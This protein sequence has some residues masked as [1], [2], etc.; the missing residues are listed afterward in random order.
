MDPSISSTTDSTADS[1]DVSLAVSSHHP[2]YSN[3]RPKPTVE[4]RDDLT[5]FAWDVIRAKLTPLCPNEVPR[6]PTFPDGY[7]GLHC[8]L[9]VTWAINSD[10]RGCIGCLQPLA[11][12]PG[13]RDYALRSAFHDSRF[14]PLSW[15]EFCADSLS[16]Q[17][18]VL[19]SFETVGRGL[20]DWTLGTHG[21]TLSF[22]D[23]STGQT[24]SATFL[25]EVPSEAE[26]S[27][28][29]TIRELA[30]KAGFRSTLFIINE[31]WGL[32]TGSDKW[33]ILDA[34]CLTNCTKS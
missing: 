4:F 27:K 1:S 29:Q 24:L 17:I 14:R 15:D 32:C 7:E 13:I 26:F 19:H 16:C 34:F 10:L 12:N 3:K 28:E 22:E 11:L 25:P 20:Y 6:L 30:K 5:M 8:P 31:I 9:F 33:S 21:I 23:A 18:S 2:H